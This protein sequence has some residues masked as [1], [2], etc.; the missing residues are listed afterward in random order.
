MAIP[1]KKFAIPSDQ[2]RPVATGRGGCFASDMITVRGKPVAY[3]YRQLPRNK[4]DSGWVFLAGTESQEYMDNASN[5]EIYDVNTI[6]NYDQG[7]VPFL[8]TPPPCAFERAD[9]IGMFVPA[10]P[11]DDPG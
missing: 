8:D 10:P 7:I 4:W 1:A 9:G 2:I 5:H 6:A 11:P 3:M